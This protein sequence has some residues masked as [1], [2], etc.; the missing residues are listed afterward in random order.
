M[1]R[2]ILSSDR[3]LLRL[4]QGLFLFNIA[5]ALLS[6][7]LISQERILDEANPLW[8]SLILSNPGLFVVAKLSIAGVGCL[9]L[10]K[11]REMPAAKAGILL[12]FLVYYALLCGFYFF[13]FH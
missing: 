2:K 11:Y 6:V 9:L 1:I 4:V 8:S 3:V 10:H 13:V 7:Q 5:D 12:C